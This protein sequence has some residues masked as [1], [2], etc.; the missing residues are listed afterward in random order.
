M[1]RLAAALFMVLLPAVANAHDVPAGVQPISLFDGVE[2]T[3]PAIALSAENGTTIYVYAVLTNAGP[4]TERL[5]SIETPFGPATF[6][7]T[8]TSAD[9]STRTERLAWIE[10]PPGVTDF[11][12][13]TVRGRVDN[14]D[15][16]A[17]AA[18]APAA[19]FV[20]QGRGRFDLTLATIAN[21]ND[22]LGPQ[23][24]PT[25]PRAGDPAAVTAAVSAVIG[26][27]SV[28]APIAVAGDVAVAGWSHGDE[29]AWVFLRRDGGAWQV[30]LWSGRSLLLAATMTSL[31]VPAEGAAALRRQLDQAE[32]FLGDEFVARFDAFRGTVVL[33]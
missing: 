23:R 16:M 20:F 30:V 12:R 28:V 32:V 18:A 11:S 19:T 25:G 1:K 24:T 14:V 8:V 2:I 6:E 4:G 7:R 10:I 17:L 29:G 33:R 27:G 5:T 15:P 22:E 31:G 26:A 3:H 9:G 13:G 21:E